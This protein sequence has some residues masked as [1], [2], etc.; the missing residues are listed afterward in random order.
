[1]SK[2]ASTRP[3][4]TLALAG[5]HLLTGPVRPRATMREALTVGLGEGSRIALFA[6]VLGLYALL[7]PQV[8]SG[9]GSYLATIRQSPEPSDWALGGVLSVML[10]GLLVIVLY[11]SQSAILHAAIWIVTRAKPTFARTRSVVA[12]A[13]W[14][15]VVPTCLVYLAMRGLF[16]ETSA[17]SVFIMAG[18]VLAIVAPYA[19]LGIAE[20]TGSSLRRSA[21]ILLLALLGE[22]AASFGIDAGLEDLNATLSNFILENDPA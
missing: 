19:T 18:A 2:G 11:L 9:V 21:I 1:M 8:R 15:P 10:L 6:A 22:A 16:Q 17:G 20:A 3:G 5:R 12:I 13:N 4:Y 7:N 14:I